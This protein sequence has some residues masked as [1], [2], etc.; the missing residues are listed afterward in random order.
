LITTNLTHSDQV[1]RSM[2]I[3]VLAFSLLLLTL[4]RRVCKVIKVNGIYHKL[5]ILLPVM[6]LWYCG[7]ASD[8]LR[9]GAMQTGLFSQEATI[10]P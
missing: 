8:S 10:G 2:F 5:L 9:Q 3:E 6:V 1:S 4:K 7:N